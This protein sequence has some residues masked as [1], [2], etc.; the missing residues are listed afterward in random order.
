M[1][2]GMSTRFVPLS[3]EV[4]KALLKVKGEILIERQIEQLKEAGI[5]EIIVVTGYLKDQFSYLEK[6]YGVILIE[7]PVYQIRNN[8]STIYV[9]R[10]YLRDTFICSGDN[11][12]VKNVFVEKCN[13][14]YYS[15]VY[16]KGDT[17]EWCL[18]VDKKGRIDRVS[19]GG[20]SAWIMKGPAYFTK[21]FSEAFLPY[22]EEAYRD[23]G[24]ENKFWEEIYMEH[25]ERLN[26]YI[27]KYEEGIIEEFDTLEELKKF[28]D[29]YQKS[30]GSLILKKISNQLGCGENK[31][32]KI[33]PMKVCGVLTGFVF[34]YNKQKFVYNFE[35]KSLKKREDKKER[36]ERGYEK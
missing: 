19:I 26:M 27:H 14:S 13:F 20:N 1:A 7:N 33:Q 2:A 8:H 12:F 6:M 18:S 24:S 31:L 35:T 34:Q 11:Y 28:D 21:E 5:E 23:A 32:E 36:T 25:I 30:T 4:P 9:A 10:K 17:D 16:E 29:Q 22:L 15:A 3:L